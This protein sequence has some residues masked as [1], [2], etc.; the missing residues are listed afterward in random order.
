MVMG[1][2]SGQRSES[3]YDDIK[4]GPS[5]KLPLLEWFYLTLVRLRLGLLVLDVANRFGISQA[6]VSQITN[7]W[8]NLM[9]HSLKC[10]ETFPSWHVVKNICLKLSRKIIQIQELLLM[11]Q[12]F[13][14]NGLL[15]LY[16]K[17]ARFH[18]IKIEIPLKF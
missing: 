13:Q 8:I 10:I 2:W 16:L 5:C 15:L 17:P 12:N 11:P 3:H 4:V 18:H 1:Q 6:S 7:T 14:L 9:Y